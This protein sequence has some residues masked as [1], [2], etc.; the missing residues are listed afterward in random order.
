MMK[1]KTLGIDL[2]TTN[3]V[4]ALL[5]ATDSGI[6]TGRDDQ[7][8]MTFP[9][10]IAHDPVQG[11]LVAGRDAQAL[12]EACN[13]AV[14]PLSSVNVST[15]ASL[16]PVMVMVTVSV[17]LAGVGSESSVTV[18]SKLSVMVSP[19]ARNCTAALATL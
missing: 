4:I 13:S 5:D 16:A 9:S 19:A 18:T 1:R 2:G 15:G 6:I 12:K 10:V 17:S 11:C 3:S 8:R 7:G 14:L